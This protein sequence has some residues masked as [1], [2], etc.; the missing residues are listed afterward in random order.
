MS[1]AREINKAACRRLAVELRA[2][3]GLEPQDALDPWALAELYGV[4]VIPLRN[5]ALDRIV[6]EHFTVDK[7][8]TFSGA[9]IPLGAGA[10]IIENDAHADVRRRSTLGHELAHVASEHTFGTSLV[11]DRGCRKANRTQEA[12]AYE[13]A[14]ELLVPFAA[15]KALARRRATD[16][17]VALQFGVSVELARWRMN[18]SGARIIASRQAA[19][20][21]RSTTS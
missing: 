15:A 10:I 20:Y 3:L 19:A 2:E 13:V 16:E 5:L 8:D 4:R 11:D 18:S 9:L 14:G 7:P 17:E 6:L 12:E 21:A 1:G